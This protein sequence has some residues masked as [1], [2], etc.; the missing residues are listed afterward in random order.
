LD[1]NGLE[2]PLKRKHIVKDK[3]LLSKGLC[4]FKDF[5]FLNALKGT[6]IIQYSEKEGDDFLYCNAWLR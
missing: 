5:I 6:S 2:E 3:V 4:L 1:L